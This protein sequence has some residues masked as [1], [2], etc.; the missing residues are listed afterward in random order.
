[1]SEVTSSSRKPDEWHASSNFNMTG[2]LNAQTEAVKQ[3]D[4]SLRTHKHCL[5]ENL[6]AYHT[7][8]SSLQSK[9]N[10][11]RQ[12]GDILQKRIRSVTASISST[13]QT[14]AALEEAHNAKNAPLQLCS[15]RMDQRAK[16]P[17]R[18]L[19]RDAFEI[20]LEDEKDMLVKC[21]TSLKNGLMKTENCIA[22]LE[23]SLKDLQ[24]DFQ[25]KSEALAIDEHCLRTTH[26]S[27]HRAVETK[28]PPLAKLPQ[29]SSRG[30]SLQ[31]V[32]NED[33]RQSDTIRRN[34]TATDK[35]SAAQQLREEMQRL[36]DQCQRNCEKAKSNTET[37]MQARI[38]ENQT[39][40]KRLE[41]EIR[42]ITDKI[43]QT[44]STTSETKAQIDSLIEPTKLCDTR[45]HWRKTRPLREQILDPVSTSLVEHRMHLNNTSNQLEQRRR[46]EHQTL[47]TLAKHKQQLKED[48]KDKTTALQIDLDCLSHAN[49]YG[50][51]SRIMTP[52][53]GRVLKMAASFV[54]SGGFASGR[55]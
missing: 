55:P 25:L 51:G 5:D 45:D 10:T 50:K 8:N 40:R 38:Q 32:S 20:A 13:K 46:E 11:T 6:T 28:G 3:C 9:V 7:L 30:F 18:E 39:M 17:H 4:T 26:K 34:T 41:N 21:H 53:P 44:T 16:R 1:M 2:A 49:V 47:S 23:D 19:I 42:E 31:N 35:E 22:S 14:L 33:M 43:Q 48:L 54:P 36:I 15:W 12:L 24:H 52:R 29:V 37:T 27:W